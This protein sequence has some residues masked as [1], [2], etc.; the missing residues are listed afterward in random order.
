MEDRH[1]QRRRWRE[2]RRQWKENLKSG[3]RDRRVY[4]MAGVHMRG[5]IWTGLFILLIGVAALLK[6]ALVPLPYWVFSWPMLLIAI[7]GFIGLRHGFRG[8]AWL[9]LMLIGAAFLADRINP[10]IEMRR[11]TWPAVLIIVGL[12]FIFRPR[13]RSYWEMGEKKTSA[14]MPND[15]VM[16]PEA[17][18]SKEDYVNATSIFGGAKKN[19]LSKNFKGGELTN[20]FGGTELNLMQADINGEAVIELTT[21]FGGTTLVVPSNWTV[22][23]DAAVVFGGIDDKRSMTGSTEVA[24]KTL[25]LRGTV[26]FGGID[27]K[28]Y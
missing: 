1:E 6:A 10:D 24:S 5:N 26:I 22:K 21:L 13:R 15:P 2:E 20:I 9:I 11:Y 3:I 27:I 8:V 16:N 19:I 17:T 14:D 28:S 7:G 18:D 12:Y 4:M 23:S 25:T